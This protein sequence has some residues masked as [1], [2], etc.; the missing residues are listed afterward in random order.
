MN[1]WDLVGLVL[2]GAVVFVASTF[3]FDV[4]HYLL[5]KWSKSKVPLLREFASWHNVHHKF[6]DEH[7]NIN[8]EWVKA[9]FWAHLLP[10]FATS[11]AGTVV[12]YLFFDW[13]PVTVIL[14]VHVWKFIGTLR[15]EGIDYNHMAMDRISGQTGL[16]RV[17]QSY[18]ALHHIYPDNF[19]SSYVNVF[20]ML[21]G[22]TC[23]IRK[24]RFLVT[25]ASG[26]FGRALVSRLRDMGAIVDTAKHGVDFAPADYERMRDK[27]ARTDVLVLAHG[28]KE[29][30]TWN[31][32]FRTPTE[33]ADMFIEVGK[34]RLVPAEI[35]GLGSE[36]EIHGDMGMAD[37]KAY[38]A[39]KRA[40]A[41]RAL[42][43]YLDADV[44]YRH[45]VPS[46]FTS[47]MGKGPM[48]AEFAVSY[49]MFF[50]R[51]G[52]KYVPVTLTTLAFWNYFRFRFQPRD[53]GRRVRWSDRNG[54]FKLLRSLRRRRAVDNDLE[55]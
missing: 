13:I 10:E 54:V 6:L 50:I 21:F 8:P 36:V 33:L 14:L 45:I 30:D 17:T 42:D 37:L 46:A 12:F 24:R 7:M 23:K 49:A 41:A 28:S 11:I 27:L 55:R 9:N 31:A 5:H 53:A 26:A 32:N 51:R 39:S 4:V 44:L 40:F 25:G 2:Q 16:W 1:V 34:Q 43:Y 52:F 3:I 19:Y 47:A 48:S 35:W 29:E 22:T 38:A 15:E 18:H 20:D